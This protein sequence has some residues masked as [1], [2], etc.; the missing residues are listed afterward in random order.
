MLGDINMKQPEQLK[1]DWKTKNKIRERVC[2]LNREQLVVRECNRSIK[3]DTLIK[4][5]VIAGTQNRLQLRTHLD[6][7]IRLVEFELAVIHDIMRRRGIQ[8]WDE[9]FMR[10]GDD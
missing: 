5:W 8:V 1:L 6:E 10:E 2:K 4:E 9:H 7:C 3:R